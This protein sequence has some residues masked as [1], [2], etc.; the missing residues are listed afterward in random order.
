MRAATDLDGI[1]WSRAQRRITLRR[2]QCRLRRQ[3]ITIQLFALDYAYF[4]LPRAQYKVFCRVCLTFCIQR[5]W[6]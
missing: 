5:W 3:V 2:L 4:P 1:H 6:R